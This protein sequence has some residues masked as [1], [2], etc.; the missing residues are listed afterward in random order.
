MAITGGAK[1]QKICGFPLV[2]SQDTHETQSSFDK[3]QSSFLGVTCNTSRRWTEQL[4]QVFIKDSP[5]RSPHILAN[6][7]HASEVT[8]EARQG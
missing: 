3:V 6:L 2:I 5:C 4:A 1:I 7:V 8:T